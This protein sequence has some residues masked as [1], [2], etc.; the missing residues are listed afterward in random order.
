MTFFD[1]FCDFGDQNARPHASVLCYLSK[2][3]ICITL[4]PGVILKFSATSELVEF[5]PNL[6]CPPPFFA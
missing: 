5:L 2:K 4:R 3:K 6:G 1:F